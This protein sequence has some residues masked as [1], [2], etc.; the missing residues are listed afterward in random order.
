[1]IGKKDNPALSRAEITLEADFFGEPT[2]KKEAIRKKVSSMEKKDEK[3]VVIKGI[4]GNFGSR[5]AKVTA[6][7]YSSEESL[8]KIEPKKKK[9]DKAK[10]E[11][12]E[13]EKEKEAPKEEAKK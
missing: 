7:I 11:G 2:P 4:K 3:L 12:K 8:K 13:A 10:G 5:T 9:E 6:Y 1:M